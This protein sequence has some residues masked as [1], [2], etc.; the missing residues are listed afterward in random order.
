MTMSMAD[1]GATDEGHRWRRGAE[2]ILGVLAETEY[3]C[4]RCPAQR[5]SYFNTLRP[6]AGM[7]WTEPVERG[8]FPQ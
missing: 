8:H 4:R 6:D 1:C 2:G 3:L 5:F 7:R